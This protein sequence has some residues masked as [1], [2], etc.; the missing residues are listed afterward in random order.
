MAQVRGVG[1]SYVKEEEGSCAEGVGGGGLW[2][3]V[4]KGVGLRP[5]SWSWPTSLCQD[6]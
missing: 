5:R 1:L 6:C 3:V 2:R 4:A